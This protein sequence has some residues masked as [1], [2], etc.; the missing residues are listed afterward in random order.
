MPALSRRPLR[1]QGPTRKSGSWS[2]RRGCKSHIPRVGWQHT[3]DAIPQRVLTR[4]GCRCQFPSL[5]SQCCLNADV[6]SGERSTSR[7]AGCTISA[8]SCPCPIC[9]RSVLPALGVPL[10]RPG[11]RRLVWVTLCPVSTAALMI[12]RGSILRYLSRS[13]VEHPRRQRLTELKGNRS[14]ACAHTHA[15]NPLRVRHRRT[16]RRRFRRPARR[17]EAYRDRRR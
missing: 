8:V 3:G 10:G 14:S 6:C 9:R 15:C 1:A 17:R 11:R 5:P 12:V 16:G 2:L 13:G 4:S 7:D